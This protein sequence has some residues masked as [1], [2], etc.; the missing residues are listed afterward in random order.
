MNTKY[1]K[2]GQVYCQITESN[3]SYVY[4]HLN[5]KGELYYIGSGKGNRCNQ[6]ATRTS[7]WKNE[8]RNNGLK[9][10][11]IAANMSKEDAYEL[12]K[13]LIKSLQPKCNMQFGGQSG[14]D[15][16]LR[17][18]VYC[19]GLDGVYKMKFNSIS[20][21]Y[22]Y[23]G[24]TDSDSKISMC[25]SGKKRSYKGHMFKDFYL[26]KIE[27]YRK[28]VPYNMKKVYRYDLNGYF[29]EELEKI[30]DFKEGSRTGICNVMDKDYTCY[31]SFWRSFKKDKIEVNLPSPALR[32]KRKIID[33]VTGDIYDSV[34]SASNSL[35]MR[36]AA[37]SKKLKH[38]RF[39][40]LNLR[41]L[42]E[43]V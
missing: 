25:L 32:E 3:K 31:N 29:I 15:S 6:I 1:G 38:K 43:Q 11:F 10:L 28:P 37:L 13:S 4:A 22:T 12:E 9:I 33:I 36:C 18:E 42:N 39:K 2:N 30:V 20:D 17:K 27:P 24:G 21:A 16:G 26:E 7:Y 8:H 5:N 23:F 34:S 41:Y 14:L 40:N 35:G 19:Y